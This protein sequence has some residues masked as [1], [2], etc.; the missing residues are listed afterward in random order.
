MRKQA[1]FFFGSGISFPS[2]MPSVYDITKSALAEDWHFHTD[3][4]FYPGRHPGAPAP[5]AVTVAAKGFLTKVN[6]C[7]ADYLTDLSRHR[8]SRKPHYED[9]FS[10]AEQ[11]SRLATDYTPNLAVVEFLR[12][13]RRETAQYHC[14]FDR[15]PVGVDG[16]VGLATIACDF[17]HW[18]VHHNLNRAS[19]SRHGLGLISET[20]NAV[21]ALDIFTLNHDLL[22]ENQ[23]KDDGIA[24]VEAGF[25]DKNHGKFSVFGGWSKIRRKKVRLFKLHGSLNWHLYDFPNWARQY[26]IPQN[27]LW[28]STDENGNLVRPVEGKAAFLSGTIVKEQRYGLGLWG[29]LF[30]NFREHLSRHTHLIC[31]GYGFGDP[32]I[33]HRLEQWVDDRLDGSNRLVILAPG[34][35]E[36][37]L[38]DKPLWLHRLF[39]Q[40]R[41]LFVGAYLENCTLD[42]IAGYFDALSPH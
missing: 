34:S 3:Q 16:F 9:W 6:E 31:C 24:D 13:L 12:C 7:A 22:V 32:G 15:G 25:D 41:V 18:V 37:F 35:P 28:H 11:A 42:Q 14:G 5:D 26:A 10:L 39:E 29:E 30:S 27:D 38:A 23:L 19:G 8:V 2:K 1:A 17:L 40:K 33:N 21:D 36:K 20:A 4:C